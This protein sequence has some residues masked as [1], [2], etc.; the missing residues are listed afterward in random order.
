MRKCNQQVFLSAALL[1][2]VSS[3]ASAVIL[4]TVTIGNPGNAPANPAAGVFRGSVAVEFGI[5]RTEVT[6]EQYVEF[7][8]AV[9]ADGSNP[10]SLYNTNMTSNAVGGIDFNA[11]ASNGSKY[12]VKAGRAAQP[13]VYVNVLDAMR[14]A[15]WL[16]NGQGTGDTETGAYTMSLANPGRNPNA[17]VFV[18][19]INEW[20]KSA[21]HQPA[22][23]G[24]DSDDYWNF[25]TTGNTAPTNPVP[26]SAT[27]NTANYKAGS[28]FAVTQ[29]GGTAVAGTNY[30]SDVGA[31]SQSPSY[32][33]TFDQA[34]NVAEWVDDV[35]GTGRGAVGGSWAA[36][37]VAAFVNVAAAPQTT[38][39]NGIGFRLAIPEPGALGLMT[40]MMAAVAL[41]T[42]R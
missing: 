33:N 34:G 15:N 1:G 24:G 13:V 19:N 42:R 9:D 2:T 35:L 38:E 21:F 11:G 7:L 31:Y 37:S 6:N 29:V 32:Y 28:I 22:S 25:A 5:G 16:Q 27:A 12:S 23:A 20:Y 26:P 39:T 36:T 10:R 41:R 8:N 40:T 18:P 4:D 14:M 17:T 30:L 3:V